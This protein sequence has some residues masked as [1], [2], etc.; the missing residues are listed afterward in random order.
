MKILLAH[1]TGN[2]NVRAALKG[3]Q[4]AKILAAFYTSIACFSN[5][6]LA[7]LSKLPT[8]KEINR[9]RFDSS[10]QTFTTLFFFRELGRLFASKMKLNFLTKHET[11]FFCI[12]SVY[13]NVDLKVSIELKKYKNLNAI[14]A[15]EDS[16]L[17]SFKEAKRLQITCIYDL[18]IGYWRSAR[19]LLNEERIIRPE[20]SSTLI[21]FKDSIKKLENK[22]KEIALADHIIVASSFTKKTLEEYPGK[23]ASITV[24]PYGFPPVVY[25]RIYSKLVDRPLRLLFVGGLSQRKGIANIFEAVAQL[26]ESV[27]LTIVG[28]KSVE[29][30]QSLNIAI[31]Q[32]RYIPSLP[33]SEVL[34][35]MREHDVFVFPSL[36]EGFGLV[37][38]EAMSQGT[39]VITTNRTAGVDFIKHGEN[40][41]LVEAGSTKSLIDCIKN[42]LDNPELIEL[43]GRNALITAKSRPW[44]KYS[45]DLSTFLKDNVKR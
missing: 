4:D 7:K 14:Y 16:A 27:N 39:P 18:P 6:F 30:C 9:R 37:I 5:S 12:D 8:F 35:L 36:F 15:Y 10:L 19:K 13:K 24:I 43:N 29:D 31:Q 21:G 17:N 28:N 45:N 3:I 2:A 40:G 22:D 42:I 26:G 11:G 25:N 38:T 20:W 1:P 23:I 33:H 41:W 44:S 32:H 34:N